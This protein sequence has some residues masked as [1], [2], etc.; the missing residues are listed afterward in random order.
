MGPARQLSLVAIDR[1]GA[2]LQQF[3]SAVIAA[4]T[5]AAKQS[6]PVAAYLWIPVAVGGGLVVLLVLVTGL[7]GVPYV[8][9]TVQPPKEAQTAGLLSGPFWKARFY[10]SAAW[11]FGDSWA[12]N[13]TAFATAL[14]AIVASGTVLTSIFPN[15]DLNPFILMN[16][17]CGA[18]VA[19]GPVL[20]AITNVVVMRGN[21]MLPVDASLTLQGDARISLPSGASIALSGGATVKSASNGFEK[22]RIKPGGTIP[23]PPG[24]VITVK[25]AATVALPSSAAVTINPGAT[26]AISAAT[27]VAASSLAPPQ[28]S[29]TGGHERIL[30]LFPRPA[31]P[32]ITAGDLI[33]V[34]EGAVAT[35]IGA[36]DVSLDGATMVA[37]GRGG[38]ALKPGTTLTVP[39][40]SNVMAA[41][42]GSV[43]SAAALTTFGI[44]AELGLITVLAAHYS[45]AGHAG[46]VAA[47]VISA[48]VAAGLVLYGATGIRSLAD[49]TPGSSLSSGGRTSFTL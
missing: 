1:P 14:A 34:T 36:A 20:F 37:P 6:V 4:S 5:A 26:L 49:P 18:I 27:E 45:T 38:M 12:T 29:R 46:R 44:G 13:I 7:V 10:A 33:T 9:P 48:V 17:A 40:G 16:L 39:A 42:M 25:S 35:V 32:H 22:A 41:G 8:N 15:F 31:D 24:S 2:A 21:P 11:T 47:V 3:H 30:D 19:A 28:A 43:L 23:I